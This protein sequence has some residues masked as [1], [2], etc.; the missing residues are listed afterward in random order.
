M[1][2]LFV[3]TKSE[4]GGAQTHVYQLAKALHEKGHEPGIM[5]RPGGWLEHVARN[6]EIPFYPNPYLSNTINAL[7]DFQAGMRLLT[8]VRDFK[9]DL[10]SCH[11]SKAGII[12]RFS[13]RG[14][15]PT[16][17]T[18]H[19]W[20][21]AERGT[22][23]KRILYVPCEKLATR[24]TDK[25]ICVSQYL[26]TVALDLGI[27]S[28]DKLK[29][30]HNGAEPAAES[31]SDA[32]GKDELTILFV[33]R[34]VSQKDPETLVSAYASLPEPVRNRAQLRVI[35]EGDKRPA[36]E[37]LTRTHGL[38]GPVRFLGALNRN[39]VLDE[40]SR[41][42]IFVLTTHYEGLPRTAIEAMHAGLPI[43]ASNVW[44][45]R[46]LFENPASNPDD[47]DAIGLL[48]AES[49]VVE[50]RRALERLITD[51]ALRVGMGKAARRR[52]RASFSV[53]KMVEETM[54]VYQQV[55]RARR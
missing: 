15:I 46:E 34:L 44:G 22:L 39:A 32:A 4:A 50:V 13:V 54:H 29:V 18:A 24:Y 36:L 25:L 9:P 27:A 41:A 5:A 49:D 7:R 8:V 16:V 31:S 21:F 1:K 12:A 45:V 47:R 35:G 14:R 38:K 17:F 43:I 40:F 33:G 42:D 19:G 26:S 55:I 28:A 52:A 11:S 20:G 37:E 51:T 48:V 23:L 6:A 2:I 53:G 10:M 30:I 3:I